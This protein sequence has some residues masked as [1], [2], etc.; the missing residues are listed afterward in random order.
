VSRK[1]LRMFMCA[2]FAAALGMFGTAAQATFY[3]GD[4]DPFTGSFS[5]NVSDSCNSDGCTID[6]LSNMFIKSTV[7]GC[8][9]TSPGQL[10]IGPTSEGTVF[11]EGTGDLIAF[12]S[13]LIPLSF[14]SDDRL[15]ANDLP[16]CDNPSLQFTS[17]FGTDMNG[18]SGYLA[19]LVCTSAQGTVTVFDDARYSLTKV[20]EPGTLALILGGLGAGWLTRRRKVAA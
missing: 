17:T 16:P 10:G 13:Q 6:L 2:A 20:P 18:D 12:D 9:W 1:T 3:S 11:D 5:L 19:Q 15:F 14:F 8:C 7:F 4:F